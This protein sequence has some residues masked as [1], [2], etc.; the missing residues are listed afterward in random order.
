MTSPGM[1]SP[2]WRSNPPAAPGPRPRKTTARPMTTAR[3]TAPSP[4]RARAATRPKTRRPRT[5]RRRPAR[6]RALGPHHRHIRR[7]ARDRRRHVLLLRHRGPG[8]D[9][10]RLYRRAVADDLAQGGRLRHRV[11]G[12]RQPA[13]ERRA[14]AGADRPA[15]LRRG[16]RFGAGR[17]AECPGAAEGGAVQHRDRAEELPRPL[18]PGAGPV[19]AGARPTVSGAD[20]IQASAQ[21]GARGDDAAERGPVHRPAPDRPGPGSRRRRPR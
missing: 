6:R 11:A 19:A 1:T 13:G 18:A 14:G 21:R 3:G 20:R 16:A 8:I 15:G 7:A 17:P 12:G 9:G 2:G 4:P 10:R 5:S